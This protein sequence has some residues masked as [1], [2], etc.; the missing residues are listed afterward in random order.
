MGDR[1][2]QIHTSKWL[3]WTVGGLEVEN[4]RRSEK[5]FISAKGGRVSRRTKRFIL[6]HIWI[7][8]WHSILLNC[9]R[10]HSA[11]IDSRKSQTVGTSEGYLETIVY[12][13]FAKNHHPC[14]CIELPFGSKLSWYATVFEMHTRTQEWE[15]QSKSDSRQHET[16]CEHIEL[17]V[18]IL[19][20]LLE[21]TDKQFHQDR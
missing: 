20:S 16:V 18:S 14:K 1:E 6:Q 2:K 10:Q 11:R 12:S 15:T 4:S 7:L 8:L 13:I 21:T 17:T 3:K 19:G 5:H 9:N